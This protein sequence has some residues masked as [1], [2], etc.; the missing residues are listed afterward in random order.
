[1]VEEEQCLFAE[2]CINL[3]L[4]QSDYFMSAF[5]SKIV[6]G[7]C[8][9]NGY[10]KTKHFQFNV[11]ELNKL[12]FSIFDTIKN[13]VENTRS[14]ISNQLIATKFEQNYFFSTKTLLY[15]NNPCKVVV[16]GIED[17]RKNEICFEFKMSKIELNNFISVLVKV[18]PS[19]LC[20]NEFELLLFQK[21]SEES[22]SHIKMFKDESFSKEFVKKVAATMG[23]LIS[24][25]LLY[26]LSTLITYYCEIILIYHKFQSLIDHNEESD[27]IVAILRK[28]THAS[29]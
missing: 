8:L 20:L 9:S 18:I 3:V 5:P 19:S 26:N 4:K 21:A 14:E 7:Q 22:A 16:F 24:D 12:Y 25:Q 15:E 23:N 11:F 27:N 6:F 13:F 2:S 29:V 17:T 28:V 10:K 1:M